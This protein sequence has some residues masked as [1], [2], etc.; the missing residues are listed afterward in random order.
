MGWA[1]FDR[2][3]QLI[4]EA[5]EHQ[6]NGYTAMKLRIGTSWARSHV[7]PA[8]FLDLL[9]RLR[10]AVGPDFELMLDA[11]MRFS[12]DEAD[13][14]LELARGLREL[15]FR[16][17]EDPIMRAE[18]DA[19]YRGITAEATDADSVSVYRRLREE[20]GVPISGGETTFDPA[21]RTPP[22]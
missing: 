12:P 11:N 18:D 13:E 9:G 22:D 17:F 14:V 3:E 20:S 1:W 16:W 10:H 15:D 5:L 7:T 4:E 2:P 19:S 6:A 21:R 8:R